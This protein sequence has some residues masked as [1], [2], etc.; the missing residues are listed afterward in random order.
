M[1][2]ERQTPLAENDR[3]RAELAPQ[4]A[5]YQA[6]L[7]HLQ[8]TLADND[9][10]RAELAA[11]SAHL[12]LIQ[13]SIFWR[14]TG[15]LRRGAGLLPEPLRVLYRRRVTLLYRTVTGQF[16][17]RLRLIRQVQAP[18]PPDIGRGQP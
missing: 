8:A 7:A 17:T 10:L 9:R 12:Q 6:T 3:L 11:Q 5:T 15:V 18:L 14:A 1:T 16:R 2:T 4:T 13:N